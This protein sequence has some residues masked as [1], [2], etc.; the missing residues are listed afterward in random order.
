MAR[1]FGT[2]ATGYE[3]EVN[4]GGGGAQKKTTFFLLGGIPWRAKSGGFLFST[5]V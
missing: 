1:R 2:L 5:L 4:V 3:N